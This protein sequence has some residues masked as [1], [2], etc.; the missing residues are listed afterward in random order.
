MRQAGLEPDKE[1]ASL[2]AELVDGNLLAASQEIEKLKLL[3]P[4]N[5]LQVSAQIVRDCVVDS[6][7][8]NAFN[9]VDAALKGNTKECVKML[10]GLHDEG[11]EPLSLIWILSREVRQLSLI[12][13]DMLQDRSADQAMQAQRVWRG[14]RANRT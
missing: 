12:K 5:K 13:Q 11:V 7:R 4:E 2:L 9:L 6:A 1:A 14:Q 8:Y 3:L 10:A